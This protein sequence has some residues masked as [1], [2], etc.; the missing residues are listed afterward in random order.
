MNEGFCIRLRHLRER[1]GVKRYVMSELCGLNHNA[2]RR[3]ENGESI[4]SA[5]ALDAMADYLGVS[6]Q[7]LWRG[8]DGSAR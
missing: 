6:M 2:V 4:P 3:Y 5:E 7:Y 8:E 1:K